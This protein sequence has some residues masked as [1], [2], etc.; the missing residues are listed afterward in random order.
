MNGKMT[1]ALYLHTSSS[2]DSGR[3]QYL[4]SSKGIFIKNEITSSLPIRK[5]ESVSTI[6]VETT[7]M[8]CS[9]ISLS[10]DSPQ[11]SIQ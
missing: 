8:V 1:L 5:L 11:I 3:K 10:F 2:N 4:A 7:F 6:S 9:L